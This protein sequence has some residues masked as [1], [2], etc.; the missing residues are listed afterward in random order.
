MYAVDLSMNDRHNSDDD[1]ILLLNRDGTVNSINLNS[2]DRHSSCCAAPS[3]W[4]VVYRKFLSYY[5]ADEFVADVYTYYKHQGFYP[6]LMSSVLSLVYILLIASAT[7][8]FAHCTVIQTDNHQISF[9]LTSACLLSVPKTSW[10]LYGICILYASLNSL[11][12][13]RALVRINGI[14]RLFCSKLHISENELQHLKWSFIQSKLDLAQEWV[15]FSISGHGFHNVEVRLRLLRQTNYETALFSQGI[16][17]PLF[18]IPLLGTI[19]YYP[20]LL[21]QYIRL[22]LT[23]APNCI[24]KNDSCLADE[25][26]VESESTAVRLR[27]HLLIITVAGLLLSPL[28]LIYKLLDNVYRHL[29][30]IRQNPSVFSKR[31]WSRY[32]RL[33]LRHFNELD[34]ELDVRLSQAQ[35]L[36]NDY[37][38][39]SLNY[40]HCAIYRF[41]ASCAASLAAILFIFTG[42]TARYTSELLLPIT[43]LGVVYKLFRGL[44]PSDGRRTSNADELCRALFEALPYLRRQVGHS[45]DGD[46][47]DH[48]EVRRRLSYLL[49]HRVTHVLNEVTSPVLAPLVLFLHVRPRAQDIADFFRN[50]TTL[51]PTVG[52]VCAFAAALAY[53]DAQVPGGITE[54]S[55]E[56]MNRSFRFIMDF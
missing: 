41:L 11:A 24:F 19:A 51:V 22:S 39:D 4:P 33:V 56:K 54:S 25:L 29:E 53:E 8:L 38:D 37:L 43:A 36:A 44:L 45:A 3:E 28:V 20:D 48:P 55:D 16:I 32:G 14:R 34:H 49:T 21:S 31:V 23:N 15:R 35:S 27:R 26:R 40:T 47:I 7:L 12:I 13:G 30:M 50:H 46:P 10:F 2:L 6:I 1:D 9:N 52:D 17:S 18:R 42:V 5:N